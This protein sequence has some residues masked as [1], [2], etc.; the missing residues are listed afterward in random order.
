MGITM[1]TMTKT[2]TIFNQ[3]DPL[4]TIWANTKADPIELYERREGMFK[5]IGYAKGINW[6]EP[7]KRC[8]LPHKK[9]F[10]VFNGKDLGKCK[11]MLETNFT[12]K[13]YDIFVNGPT[14]S[15]T[16]D[17]GTKEDFEKGL[18]KAIDDQKELEEKAKDANS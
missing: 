1:D 15:V 10:E 2:T 5:F 17:L 4:G 14:R 11:A 18:K 9:D 13:M 3:D 8:N 7:R 16:F 12:S 6:L